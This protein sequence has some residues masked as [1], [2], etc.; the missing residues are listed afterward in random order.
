[1]LFAVTLAVG[2]SSPSED[3]AKH[4]TLD[5]DTIDP[6]AVNV[7]AYSMSLGPV[8]P[9]EVPDDVGDTGPSIGPR[10]SQLRVTFNRCERSVWLSIEELE[11][12]RACLKS[13]ESQYRLSLFPAIPGPDLGSAERVEWINPRTFLVLCRSGSLLVRHLGSSRFEI[14]TTR[15]VPCD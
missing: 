3:V 14:E 15:Q 7:N 11:V 8:G 4:L 1:M 12:R 2:L 6:P 13:V 10:A 5:L 9:W